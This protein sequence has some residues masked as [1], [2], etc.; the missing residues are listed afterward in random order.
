MIGRQKTHLK[1]GCELKFIFS[2]HKISCRYLKY[3]IQNEWTQKKYTRVEKILVLALV[4]S[5]LLS[6]NY[7]LK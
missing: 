3:D 2:R 1:L 4:F 6:Q 5:K 7:R